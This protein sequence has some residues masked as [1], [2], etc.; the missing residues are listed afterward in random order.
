M[1]SFR[2]HLPFV[3]ALPALLLTAGATPGRAGTPRE[4]M[5][6]SSASIQGELEPC[7][8]KNHPR[9]G[10]SRRA[11]FY[12]RVR[13]EHP[14][15]LTV[16]AGDFALPPGDKEGWPVTDF[17]SAAFARLRY[18]AWTPGERELAYGPEVVRQLA[19]T[20]GA[21]VISANLAD[22]S[23]NLLFKPSVI[24]TVGKLKVGITGVTAGDFAQAADTALAEPLR[25]LKYND[26][27]ASLTPVVAE[28]RKT[29]DVVVL[30]AHM[31][32]MEV[33]RLTRLVPGLNVVVVGHN[34]PFSAEPELAGET[35]LVGGGN[36][37][38]YTSQ[39]RLTLGENG[40]IE[41][42]DGIGEPLAAEGPVDSTMLRAV[43][44]FENTI[45]RKP[46][47]ALDS[48]EP[49]APAGAEPR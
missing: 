31:R 47:V 28:L 34:P 41:D 36:R 35:L 14:N 16:D 39:T 33:R 42:Y 5:I 2:H 49:D 26:T 43:T 10:L 18:D 1:T 25:A 21:E 29:C 3:L 37:G 17:M 22:A 44:A 46:G 7:G 4:L 13:A 30:L 27:V 19:R 11:A 40:F 8:C 23:G 6:L 20:S 15:T 48:E 9:G 45:G 24:K 32:P 12:E 38:H